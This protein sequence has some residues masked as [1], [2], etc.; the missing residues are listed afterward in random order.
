MNNDSGPLFDN[1]G[2]NF[3]KTVSAF[4]VLVEGILELSLKFFAYKSDELD[5]HQLLLEDACVADYLTLAIY[6]ANVLLVMLGAEFRSVD[7]LYLLGLLVHLLLAQES[8][9]LATLHLLHLD[10][11]VLLEGSNTHGWVELRSSCSLRLEGAS[12]C[13]WCVLLALLS[14]LL[15]LAEPLVGWESWFH[16]K[17][18]SFRLLLMN[19]A[20][21]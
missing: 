11:S 14:V 15:L 8:S 3:V 19:L 1:V 4:F 18:S 7:L 6:V 20:L 12:R 17:L 13:V 16:L 5:T 10:L 2:V 21:P 9:R